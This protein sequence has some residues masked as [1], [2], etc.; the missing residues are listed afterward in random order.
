MVQTAVKALNVLSSTNLQFPFTVL[1]S[2]EAHEGRV[3]GELVALL[4]RNVAR[5]ERVAARLQNVGPAFIAPDAVWK[6]SG[7]SGL[8]LV[9][10]MP[11][12]LMV[13]IEVINARGPSPQPANRM[14]VYKL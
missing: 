13:F 9:F 3:D 14:Q 4:R 6:H 1:A 5:V 12:T 10:I 2:F 8:T 11:Q 7:N